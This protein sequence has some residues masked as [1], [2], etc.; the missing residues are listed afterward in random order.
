MKFKKVAKHNRWSP[1]TKSTNLLNS[2][3]GAA[4]DA[5]SHDLSNFT[6]K[7]IKKKL[8]GRFGAHQ[9]H[10]LFRAQLRKRSRK[11]GESIPA[12]QGD[13]EKLVALAYPT[14]NLETRDDVANATSSRSL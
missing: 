4:E 11:P 10:E 6:Y 14:A 12:L 7:H 2:L 3:K 13:I 5:F 1:S 9:Q 8:L